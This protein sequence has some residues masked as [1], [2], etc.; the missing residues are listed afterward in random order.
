MSI[1][2]L[3]AFQSQCVK[4]LVLAMALAQPATRLVAAETITETFVAKATVIKGDTDTSNRGYGLNYISMPIVCPKVYAGRVT[5]LGSGSLADVN[6]GWSQ[7]QW[8]G[9]NG[10][11][12]LEF[13]SGAMADIVETDSK[14]QSLTI[15]G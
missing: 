12:Y 4:W 13:D 5:S 1:G 11:H 10:L 3:H 2:K 15:S 6:A 8:N 7:D 14:S 9:A